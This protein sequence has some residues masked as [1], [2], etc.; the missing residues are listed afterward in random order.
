[1]SSALATMDAPTIE[2]PKFR[3]TETQRAACALFA[4]P[5]R[6]ILLRGGS[7]SGKTFIIIRTLVVRMIRAPKSS[8]AVLRYRFNHLKETIIQGTLPSVME[9]CF[10]ELRYTLNKTDWYMELPNGSRMPFGGLDEKERT[11]KILG[12][13]HA[14]MF[15][16][17]CSQISYGARNKA[18]TR[19]AQTVRCVDTGQP[20]VMKAYYDENPPAATHWSYDMF[21]RKRQP[22][23]DELLPSPESYATMQM[24]PR[25]NQE[26]LPPEYLDILR[27]LPERDRRRFLDGE[28]LSEVPGALWKLEY[29]SLGRVAEEQLPQLT[30]IVVAV[31][32]SGSES[33][34]DDLHDEVGIV[35]CGIDDRGHGYV[36]EDATGPYSPLD[37]ARK[38]VEMYDKWAADLVVAE[39]NFGGAMVEANIRTVMPTIPYRSVSAS[40]GKARRAEPIAALYE[41]KMVHHAGYFT[42][43]EEQMLS[44]TTDGY[45]GAGSPN[46]AD[47][48][49]WAL[50][51]LMQPTKK[52]FSF[53]ST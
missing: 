28:F 11:E 18:V 43:M 16:N 9:I 53:T 49:V 51:E 26:N 12:Q 17:E 31:D 41:K 10:P 25:E 35:V 1:M 24:N 14:S 2:R 45:K 27:S 44:M 4:S 22:G 42:E 3:M 20:L 23:S 13:E 46:N 32:P 21:I 19:L 40:R 5:A 29:I 39:T 30:R 50:T 7:R 34:D 37:W 38:V 6:H 33:E 15:L 52:P 47:A 8:H 48:A 36:L